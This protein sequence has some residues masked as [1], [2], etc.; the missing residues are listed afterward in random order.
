[1]LRRGFLVL[2][3]TMVMFAGTGCSLFE[4]PTVRQKLFGS[5]SQ[6]M[7]PATVD[8]TSKGSEAA[9]ITPTRCGRG[10]FITMYWPVPV[11]QDVLYL[12]PEDRCF[13]GGWCKVVVGC[14]LDSYTSTVKPEQFTAIVT[15]TDSSLTVSL[16][17]DNTPSKGNIYADTKYLLEHGRFTL[18]ASKEAIASLGLTPAS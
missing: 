11:V 10:L 2:L 18:R 7:L 12:N 13:P 17:G 16:A 1:M 14:A 9:L 15:N 3:F 5:D 4:Q 6:D 8:C